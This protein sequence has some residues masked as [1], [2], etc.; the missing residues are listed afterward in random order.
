MEDSI[1]SGAPRELQRV[2]LVSRAFDPLFKVHPKLL[3]HPT[4][5]GKPKSQGEG[6]DTAPELCSM[7]N[8]GLH[9]PFH[10][11]GGKNYA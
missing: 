3:D 5:K 10:F 6:S 7:A 4:R 9:A 2:H 1:N 8:C 11:F